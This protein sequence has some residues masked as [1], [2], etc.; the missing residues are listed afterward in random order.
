MAFS[1]LRALLSVHWD[2][3]GGGGSSEG[4]TGVFAGGNDGGTLYDVIDY[5]TT[6]ST[7][8]ATDF[9]NLSTGASQMSGAVSSNTGPGGPSSAKSVQEKT[10]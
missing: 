3:G 5:V 10:K 1:S 7:G 9:G 6:A 8:N 4:D 2:S